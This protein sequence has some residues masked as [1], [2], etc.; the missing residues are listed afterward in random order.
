MRMFPSSSPANRRAPAE[1]GGS[2]PLPPIWGPP[3][4]PPPPPPEPP[5]PPP[6]EHPGQECLAPA[7]VDQE[8][9]RHLPA[10]AG[11][12]TH[13]DR[14][15]LPRDRGGLDRGLLEDQGARLGSVTEE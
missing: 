12:R 10:F 5:R 4:P 15:A 1:G 6:P 9:A 14:D 2:G 8:G 7:G 11:A 3:P 13:R